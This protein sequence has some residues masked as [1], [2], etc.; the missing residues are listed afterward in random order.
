MDAEYVTGPTKRR[1][2]TGFDSTFSGGV[3]VYRSKTQSINALSSTEAYLIDVVT[4][5]KKARSLSSMLRELGFPQY[6]PIPI[7]K[8][9]DPIIYILNYII[10]TERTCCIDVQL[11]AI[12]SYNYSGDI[13]IQKI[14]LIL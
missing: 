8:D 2:T 9:N 13:I 12:Q 11:F 7:C 5:V 14:S 1:F 3:F 6:C 10:P 4:S